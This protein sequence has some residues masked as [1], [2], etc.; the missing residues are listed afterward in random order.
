MFQLDFVLSGLLKRVCLVSQP[1]GHL[2][3]LRLL[4]SCLLLERG[5][6]LLVLVELG[7]ELGVVL[8]RLVELPLR[9]YQ[10]AFELGCLQLLPHHLLVE[11]LL[12]SQLLLVL[13]HV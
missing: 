5:C 7:E 13:A 9:L 10:L 6:L 8:S 3:N 2:V 4:L 11:R 12:V 1:I